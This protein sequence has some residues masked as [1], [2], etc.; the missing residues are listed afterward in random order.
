MKTKCF[1]YI[2]VSSI[3]QCNGD[4]FER[5]TEACQKYAE[6]HNMDIVSIFKEMGVSGTKEERKALAEM[7]VSLEENGHGV[8]TVIVEKLD[9]LSRDLMVQEKLVADLRAG[10]FD[11][12]S[13][14][15]GADLLSDDPTRKFVRQ[16]L[17]A[18]A[19]LDKSMLVLK[20]RAAR[21]RKKALTGKCEGKKGY[22]DRMPEI[23]ETIKN[24]HEQGY[25][26][27]SIAK[28]L[29]EKAVTI[30][31]YSTLSGIQ[32]TA[33]NVARINRGSAQ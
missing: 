7:M 18:V 31:R 17:G 12:V 2:R 15:E 8:K 9:R 6:A 28:T 26:F 5:Q 29:N 27:P 3:G 30:P 20:L 21:E 4:G 33:H 14:L 32:W 24:W 16:V 19:E 11:L 13:A 1:S 22:A 23:I 25:S 10:G